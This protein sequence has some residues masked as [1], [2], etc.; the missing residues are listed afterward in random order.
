[1]LI[2]IITYTY[3]YMYVHVIHIYIIYMYLQRYQS[4]AM[5]THAEFLK[6]LITANIVLN[7][8]ASAYYK[9]V[10]SKYFL[11]CFLNSPSLF[12]GLFN[13]G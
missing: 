3:L 4:L 7:F 13:D 5:K 11:G 1:M 6:D 12:V 8:L 9:I 10:S 2:H